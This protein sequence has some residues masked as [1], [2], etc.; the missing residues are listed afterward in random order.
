MAAFAVAA[1]ITYWSS[2]LA[3]STEG[4]SANPRYKLVISDQPDFRRFRLRLESLDDRPLCLDIT[5]WPNDIGQLHFGSVWATLRSTQGTYMA[6][7]ENFGRCIGPSCTI[8]IKP[9]SSLTGFIGYSEFGNPKKIAKLSARRLQL[10][11]NPIVCRAA[12]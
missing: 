9:R 5:R 3:A 7:D 11:I 12:K 10:D 8:H 2:A 6:R 4:R 1:L